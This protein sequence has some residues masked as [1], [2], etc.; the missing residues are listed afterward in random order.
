MSRHSLENVQIHLPELVEKLSPGEV[1]QI[2]QGD[3]VVAQLMAPLEKQECIRKPG[4][5][6]GTLKILVDDDESLPGL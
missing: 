5:A 2:T 1:I 3:R 6:V 4:S